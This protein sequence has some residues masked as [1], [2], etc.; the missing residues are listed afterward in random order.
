MQPTMNLDTSA[1]TQNLQASIEAVDLES[2]LHMEFAQKDN[3]WSNKPTSP[4]STSFGKGL[5]KVEY[6]HSKLKTVKRT[7]SK[8]FEVEMKDVVG[9]VTPD[10]PSFDVDDAE[11]VKDVLIPLFCRTCVVTIDDQQTMFCSCSEVECR[12]YFCADQVCVAEAVHAAK[13]VPFCLTHHDI[14]CRYCT[15]YMYLTYK[16]KHTQGYSD[17]PSSTCARRC[18]RTHSPHRQL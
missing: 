14:S 12:G 7:G 5:I 10:C 17:V 1:Q 9:L 4:H 6:E 3:T 18:S 11:N 8:A 16:K 13:C 2:I 15:D